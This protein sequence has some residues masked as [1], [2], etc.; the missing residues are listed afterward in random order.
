MVGQIFVYTLSLIIVTTILIF[1]FKII[2]EFI[3][4][5]SEVEFLNF[6]KTVDGYGKTY[7]R[8]YGSVGNKKLIAPGGVKEICFVDY[9]WDGSAMINCDGP[10]VFYPFIEDSFGDNRQERER[11]NFF[12]ISPKNEYM[13][14]YYIGN[15]S[16]R[17]S[18]NYLCFDTTKGF[19]NVQ[20]TGDG[21][22]V[23]IAKI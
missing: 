4:A 16:F 3:G 15:I 18:C 14:S 21:V 23:E 11:V 1:G 13:R 7:S 20:F 22:D 5:S 9:D 8:D 2:I 12:L 6:R 19:F 17:D 10:H